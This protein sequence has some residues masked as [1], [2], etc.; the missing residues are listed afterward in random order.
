MLE[1]FYKGF[2]DLVRPF[3]IFQKKEINFRSIFLPGMGSARLKVGI[4]APNLCRW[5][6]S[7][8]F[9]IAIVQY[10]TVQAV[11][12][13]TVLCESRQ[14]PNR[15]PLSVLLYIVIIVQYFQNKATST[16]FTLQQDVANR[17]GS[18]FLEA[19]VQLKLFVIR[20]KHEYIL[21]C[22]FVAIAKNFYCSW[23]LRLNCHKNHYI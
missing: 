10:C 16:R 21:R 17:P 2:Y 6:E 11:R 5:R 13:C 15:Q 1:L 18:T 22:H 4:N 23:Q 8:G 7:I 14:Q 19:G 9:L 3:S 12:Y 20:T